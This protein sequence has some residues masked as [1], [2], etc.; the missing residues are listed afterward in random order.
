MRGAGVGFLAALDFVYGGVFKLVYL[1]L[2]Y[3]YNGGPGVYRQMVVDIK[4]EVRNHPADE[5]LFLSKFKDAS[6]RYCRVL[7]FTLIIHPHVQRLGDEIL[8]LPAI[9]PV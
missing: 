8:P 4:N 6:S 2:T 7:F 1:C 3:L 9:Y 5:P